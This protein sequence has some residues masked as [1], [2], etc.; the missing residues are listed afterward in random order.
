MKRPSLWDPSEQGS[1][2]SWGSYSIIWEQDL[3]RLR[4]IGS[5]CCYAGF[6]SLAPNSGKNTKL[7]TMFSL[8]LESTS[9]LG[10]DLGFLQVTVAPAS[11]IP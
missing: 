5:L 1:R 9:H 6:K 11:R 10:E 8:R 4:I 3:L 7:C 2:A